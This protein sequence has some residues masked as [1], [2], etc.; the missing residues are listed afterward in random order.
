MS[1]VEQAVA[2]CRHLLTIAHGLTAD[3]ED[4]HLAVQVAPGGKTAGWILGHLAVTGDFGLRLCG[5]APRCPREWRPLYNPGSQPSPDASAY[6]TMGTLR[7]T[8]RDVYT[9]LIATAPDAD[10]LT[11]ENPLAWARVAFPTAGGFLVW[12]LSGHLGY[13]L[14]QLSGWRE[15]VGLGNPAPGAATGVGGR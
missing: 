15:A 4:A 1:S 7:H 10:A 11:A 6:A 2:Q 8:V 5:Q 13:H 12:I 3:L 9:Q 14:G